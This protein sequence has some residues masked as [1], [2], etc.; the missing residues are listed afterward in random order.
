MYGLLNTTP[1]STEIPLLLGRRPSTGKLPAQSTNGSIA[2]TTC[3]ELIVFLKPNLVQPGSLN[4]APIGQLADACSAHSS[5]CRLLDPLVKRLKT[6]SQDLELKA[7]T[8]TAHYHHRPSTS[9]PDP[10]LQWLHFPVNPPPFPTTCI[11][12]IYVCQGN[13]NQHLHHNPNWTPQPP[14]Y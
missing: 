10:T 8:F 14:S 7:L 1:P 13:S 6:R 9:K 2:G 11:R 5:Y 4:A 12:P 3:L